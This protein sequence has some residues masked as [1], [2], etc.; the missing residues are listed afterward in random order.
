[1]KSR[2]VILWLLEIPGKK[3]ISNLPPI[4]ASTV[5]WKMLAVCM[6]I[7]NSRLD[8]EITVSQ[9]AYCKDRSTKF[10]IERLTSSRNNAAYLLL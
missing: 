6:K 1:M 2:T 8:S 3:W 4:I 7:I 9:A 5:I 10:I